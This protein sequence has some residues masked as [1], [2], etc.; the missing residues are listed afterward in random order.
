MNLLLKYTEIWMEIQKIDSKSPVDHFYI[1]E[2]F[3]LA[4]KHLRE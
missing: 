3:N 4:K 1:V 2:V